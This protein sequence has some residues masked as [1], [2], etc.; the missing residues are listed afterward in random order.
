ML[1]EKM[2]HLFLSLVLVYKIFHA[3]REQEWLQLALLLLEALAELR[4]TEK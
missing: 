2:L 4:I 3:Y 1:P